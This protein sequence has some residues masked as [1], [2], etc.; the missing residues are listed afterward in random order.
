M[1]NGNSYIDR[2]YSGTHNGST[3]DMLRRIWPF[4]NSTTN[5]CIMVK[6]IACPKRQSIYAPYG[7][8]GSTT[9]E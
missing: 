3:E 6:Y 5:R 1:Y 8:R 9:S 7:Y 2:E 4:L